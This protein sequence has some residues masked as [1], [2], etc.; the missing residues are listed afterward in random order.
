[1]IVV[2]PIGVLHG[3]RGENDNCQVW[4][5]IFDTSICILCGDRGKNYFVM[6]SIGIL[7]VRR[8]MK[9]VFVTLIGILHGEMEE[10]GDY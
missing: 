1:M 10:N 4:V 9:N 3:G 5:F 6:S 8:E 2:T 7:L